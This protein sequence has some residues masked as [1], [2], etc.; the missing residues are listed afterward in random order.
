MAIT[1]KTDQSYGLSILELFG[2][3]KSLV[4]SFV[5][6][7]GSVTQTYPG[8][9]CISGNGHTFTVNVP[10]SVISLAKAGELGPMSKDALKAQFESAMSTVMSSGKP[11]LELFNHPHAGIPGEDKA[12]PAKVPAKKVAA[13]PSDDSGPVEVGSKVTGTSKSSVYTVIAVFK[14]LALAIRVKGGTTSLRASGPL[15]SNFDHRLNKVGF[16]NKGGH[17]SAHFSIGNKDNDLRVKTIGAVLATVGMDAIIQ[18][19]SP[20]DWN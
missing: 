2:I 15:L 18:V 7:G 16:S 6:A 13:L 20:S 3:S 4:S 19:A 17:S 9:F 10:G 8:K 11:S 14:G 1:F 12:I 5:S